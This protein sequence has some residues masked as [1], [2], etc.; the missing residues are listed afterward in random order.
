[1][2]RRKIIDGATSLPTICP[3]HVQY[4]PIS[5]VA[6][7][8]EYHDIISQYK[9]LTLPSVSDDELVHN[10][11]VQHHI[12]TDSL[13]VFGIV[14]SLNTE[15]LATVKDEFARMLEKGVWQP[16]SSSWASP[17]HM[18]KKI[19][20]WWL[21]SVERDRHFRPESATTCPR[22]QPGIR[23]Q[24]RILHYQSGLWKLQSSHRMGSSTLMWWHFVS[25]MHRKRFTTTWTTSSVISTS[26]LCI[27]TT[28]VCL[29]QVKLRTFS[30]SKLTLIACGKP[31]YALTW[32]T[33]L[34]HSITAFGIA[35]M[36]ERP[37]ARAFARWKSD[38]ARA[39]RLAHPIANTW[40]N[41]F[42]H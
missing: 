36:V 42:K 18:V 33:F 7:E 24:I 10:T 31:N 37:S 41:S 8:Y 26:W 3:I 15:A 25:G 11:W 28:C 9:V 34:G 1:M 14:C 17:L 40:E 13:P 4:W 27:L 38:L 32:P 23:R 29:R 2:K 30:T 35:P 12:A 5:T 22:H 16:S 20:G 39:T 21:S 6:T 19:N